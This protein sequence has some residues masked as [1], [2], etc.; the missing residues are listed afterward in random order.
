[1]TSPTNG[2]TLYDGTVTNAVSLGYLVKVVSSTGA[3]SSGVT[4]SGIRFWAGAIATFK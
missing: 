2:F 3:A 4:L 1:M